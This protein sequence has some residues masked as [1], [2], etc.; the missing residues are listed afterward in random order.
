MRAVVSTRCTKSG[1]SRPPDDKCYPVGAVV[2]ITLP[3]M[4]LF[5]EYR[6]N[7]FDVL[8]QHTMEDLQGVG[9]P[10]GTLEAIS[11]HLRSTVKGT[12]WP[13]QAQVILNE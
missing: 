10:L 6:S 4:Q 1:C 2:T 12:L 3:S 5:V 8:R 11:S 9:L 7:T 13:R